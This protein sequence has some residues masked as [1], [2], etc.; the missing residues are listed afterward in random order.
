MSQGP[1]SEGRA[2]A[3]QM[4]YQLDGG[5]DEQSLDERLDAFFQHLRPELTGKA[6]R[7]ARELCHQVIAR[8]DEVDEILT[9]SARN[10]RLERMS[11]VDRSILRVATHE[12]T[13]E[14]GPPPAVVIN[15][16]VE[17]AK[18]YGSE[19]SASFVNGVLARVNR[20]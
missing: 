10:W 4:L 15:E 7:F 19:D 17:L 5:Q 13:Q 6:R 18:A 20:G 14:E 16:A 2:A 3:V 9:R 8:L 12:L 11:R 1:R